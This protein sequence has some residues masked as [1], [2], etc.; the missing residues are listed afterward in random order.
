MEKKSDSRQIHHLHFGD[1]IALIAQSI[2]Y[3][4]RFLANFGNNCGPW[5]PTT[6][7]ES[8]ISLLVECHSPWTSE[9]IEPRYP[10]VVPQSVLV[11]VNQRKG[12]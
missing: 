11:V 8:V 2:N 1:G 12:C 6:N 9:Y 10:Q 7:L 3:A 4:E 5:S